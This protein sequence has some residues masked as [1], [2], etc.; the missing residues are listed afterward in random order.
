MKTNIDRIA[1]FIQSKGLSIRKFEKSIGASNGAIS[2][3]IIK[4]SDIGSI[5]LSKIIREYPDINPEWLLSGVG[6]MLQKDGSFEEKMYPPKIESD[7]NLLLNDE[8]KCTPFLSQEC[9]PSLDSIKK[10]DSNLM[11]NTERNN[12]S[13]P[14]TVE[15]L[16]RTNRLF[17]KLLKSKNMGEMNADLE[18]LLQD[19]CQISE[20]ADFMSLTNQMSVTAVK[21]ENIS[22][23]DFEIELENV[24]PVVNE[25]YKI[26]DKYRDTINNLY[27]ALWGLY[28]DFTNQRDYPRS[29]YEEGD[30]SKPDGVL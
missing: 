19:L 25:L 27:V 29:K 3:A 20:W 9:T 16:R 7:E 14:Y 4:Q 5:W 10:M 22:S 23:R 6:N 28:Q 12:I 8:E 1:V 26:L 2:R 13:T 30:N 11:E 24:I 15:Y 21:N 18:H 17:S